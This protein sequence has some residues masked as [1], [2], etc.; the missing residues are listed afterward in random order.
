ML[1]QQ[2]CTIKIYKTIGVRSTVKN[3]KFLPVICKIQSCIE[4]RL[5]EKTSFRLHHTFDNIY[6]NRDGILEIHFMKY[7]I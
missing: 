5:N 4:T 1:T 7:K 6:D 3:I 2:M